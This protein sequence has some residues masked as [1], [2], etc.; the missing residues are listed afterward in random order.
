M[1]W[2]V[3]LQKEYGPQGFQIIGVAMDDAS[4]EDIA[5]FAKEMG[6]NYPILLGKESVGQS[7]GGVSVLP[8]TFFLDPHAKLI[9]PQ[10]WLPNPPVF[11]HPIKKTLRQPHHHPHQ[12]NT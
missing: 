7:Y 3:E 11:V 10:F 12:H 1:P 4:L 5:K 9:A 2:F 6:V 8:P